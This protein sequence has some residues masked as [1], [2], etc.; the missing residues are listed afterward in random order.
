MNRSGRCDPAERARKKEMRPNMNEER[1]RS[2][3]EWPRM[4]ADERGFMKRGREHGPL[5]I[6]VDS[7]P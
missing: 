5:S 6:R 2:K 7:P 4:N 1:L 3:Q